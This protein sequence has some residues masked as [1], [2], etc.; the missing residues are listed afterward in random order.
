M[1]AF[2]VSTQPAHTQPV[3]CSVRAEVLAYAAFFG[4]MEAMWR[5]Y[6]PI[7]S[8]LCRSVRQLVRQNSV[9]LAVP[10]AQLTLQEAHYVSRTDHEEA[11]RLLKDVVHAPSSPDGVARFAREMMQTLESSACLCC[12][13][14]RSWSPRADPLLWLLQRQAWRRRSTSRCAASS[15][16]GP[17]SPPAP[18]WAA[19]SGPSSPARPSWCEAAAAAGCASRWPAHPAPPRRVQGP[20]VVLEDRVSAISRAEAI[21]WAR[22]DP[23]SPL[24]TG[25]V[26]NPF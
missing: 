10:V 11:L 17:R 25:H 21:M 24:H 14:T 3:L 22:V 12:L 18:T 20:A 4:A 26:L 6:A 16:R 9:P 5:D 15:L 8:A 13:H 2:S 7:V 19:G 1:P 23:F